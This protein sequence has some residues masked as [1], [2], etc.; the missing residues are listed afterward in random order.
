MSAEQTGARTRFLI[1]YNRQSGSRS[2][3]RARLLADVRFRL[4][5]AGGVVELVVFETLSEARER[6]RA[7]RQAG[8]WDALIVAGGDGTIRAVAAELTG[9]HLALAILPLG[10]ANVLAHEIG[11]PAMAADLVDVLRHGPV[12][13]LACG[14]CDGEPF[15]LMASAGFDAAVVGRAGLRTKRWIGKLAYAGPLLMEILRPA[16]RRQFAIDGVPYTGTWLIAANACHYGGSFQI[17]SARR[18]TQS[19]FQAVVIDAPTRGGVLKVLLAIACGSISTCRHVLSLPCRSIELLGADMPVQLDGDVLRG[20]RFR[21][22]AGKPSLR[23]IVPTGSELA[24]LAASN[25]QAGAGRPA[26]SSSQ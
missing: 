19:G 2:G 12:A 18:L 8:A 7:A 23:L 15:L 22:A 17:A 16:P 11:L 26:S 24:V 13:D 6:A 20:C 21:I 4:Q 14:V 1:L 25:D 10:T 3:R 5:Q 9:S